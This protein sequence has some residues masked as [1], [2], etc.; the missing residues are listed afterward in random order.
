MKSQN[1]CWTCDVNCIKET[2]IETLKLSL[3]SPRQ[4]R[5][6]ISQFFLSVSEYFYLHRGTREKERKEEKKASL[7]VCNC[8]SVKTQNRNLIVI[9]I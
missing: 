1:N 2:K 3:Y 5:K 4:F 7:F 8:A 9:I 6:P